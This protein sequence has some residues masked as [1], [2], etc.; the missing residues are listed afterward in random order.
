VLRDT[1]LIRPG[2]AKRHG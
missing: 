1:T 2:R